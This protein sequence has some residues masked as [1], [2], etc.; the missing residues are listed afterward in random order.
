MPQQVWSEMEVNPHPSEVI[1][2]SRVSR[3]GLPCPELWD[4]HVPR[5]ERDVIGF[6]PVKTHIQRRNERRWFP[7][8]FRVITEN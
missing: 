5:S 7:E 3:K 4:T 8:R 1:W 6:I 2:R